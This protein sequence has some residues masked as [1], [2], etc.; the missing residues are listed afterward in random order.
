MV[1]TFVGFLRTRIEF[2]NSFF[3]EGELSVKTAYETK[4]LQ[5]GLPITYTR[6]SLA[7]GRVFPMF[8]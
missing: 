6:F 5:R 1:L 8:D 4:F 3:A 7:G 2:I